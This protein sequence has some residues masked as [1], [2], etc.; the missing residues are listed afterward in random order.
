L[1]HTSFS[2][3]IWANVTTLA[4]INRVVQYNN[5]EDD[6]DDKSAQDD[7]LKKSLRCVRQEILLLQVACAR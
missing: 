3:M 4:N 6:D 2:F 1:L 7:I 5:D